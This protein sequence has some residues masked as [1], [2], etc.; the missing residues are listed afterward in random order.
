MTRF[1]TLAESRWGQPGQKGGGANRRL[2]LVAGC[3]V[4]QVHF[5]RN[6]LPVDGD[7]G[8]VK[9]QQHGREGLEQD[10][11]IQPLA[12]RNALLTAG[13]ALFPQTRY[14]PISPS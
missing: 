8:I 1:N 7:R 9:L 12:V 3:L 14:G 4:Y 6:P 2:N 5:A 11:G 13:K 10:G